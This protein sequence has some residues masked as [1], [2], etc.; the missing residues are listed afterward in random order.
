MTG[1][2]TEKLAETSWLIQ[3][4]GQVRQHGATIRE[5]VITIKNITKK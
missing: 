2:W 4:S 1:C 5:T 3:G